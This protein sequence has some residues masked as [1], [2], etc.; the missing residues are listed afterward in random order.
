MFGSEQSRYVY[1]EYM[2]R[3]TFRNG[4]LW[5]A[6]N[7]MGH[8]DKSDEP[9]RGCPNALSMLTKNEETRIEY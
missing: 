7:M 9:I 8:G 6:S 5:C 4:S 1:L 2:Q 3:L